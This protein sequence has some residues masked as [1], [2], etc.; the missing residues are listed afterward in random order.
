[1]ARPPQ[2]AGPAVLLSAWVSNRTQIRA[3]AGW[4]S[5]WRNSVRRTGLEC[6]LC[7][8]E[9]EDLDDLQRQM[10]LFTAMVAP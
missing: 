4:S 5:P 3:Q 1:M 2:R 10:R 9:S 7:G 6:A 8:F